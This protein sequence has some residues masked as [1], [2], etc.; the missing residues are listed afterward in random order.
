MG[1]TLVGSHFSC[2]PHA[3]APGL[4]LTRGLASGDLISQ[5][6]VITSASRCLTITMPWCPNCT[7]S[8]H[9]RVGPAFIVSG[10]TELAVERQMLPIWQMATC[11][12]RCSA[13]R[14]VLRSPSP[15]SKPVHSRFWPV[16]LCSR[17]R[18]AQQ[19]RLTARTQLRAPLF[20]RRMLGTWPPA[21]DAQQTL[22]SPLS[23]PCHSRFW[24]V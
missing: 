11:T 7:A 22:R 24:P 2:S 21:A 10:M 20:A 14:P 23:T 19:L 12:S 3:Q 6:V 18:S 8:E 13:N 17:G 1:W 9:D 5:S 4:V 16:A 15:L